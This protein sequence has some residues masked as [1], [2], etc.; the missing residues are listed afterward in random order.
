MSQVLYRKYRPKLWSEVVGQEHV[1]RTLQ[2]A[3]KSGRVVHSYLFSGSRGIGKTTIARLLSKTLNCAERKEEE[4]EPC[5]Q[6]SNCQSANLGNSL[7]I[8]EIDAA[9]HT[10]VD[11]VRDKII[12]N[13][14]FAPS[15]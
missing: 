6:C 3:I 5:N 7:S 15:G 10:G 13:V 1:T 11:N 9:S 4:S 14:R 2:N 12:E 8:I